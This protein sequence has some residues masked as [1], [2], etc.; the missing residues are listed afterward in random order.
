MA[1]TAPETFKV[2]FETTAGEFVV[3][4][5]RELAPV[6]V[7]RFHDL[8]T[9]GYYDGCRFFRVVPNF[10]VQFGMHGDPKTGA[11]WR[12]ADIK[13][14]PVKGSN[15]KKTVCFATAGP[16]TRTTQLFINL[17]DNGR[18]DGMGFAAFGEVVEGFEVVEKINP[19]Y[20]EKPRQD[21]IDK[22]G[23]EYLAE[24]FPRLDYIKRAAVIA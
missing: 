23:N 19:E 4:A 13:D 8:V 16:D 20:G 5:K 2:R 18:L 3:E 22:R 7:D 12:K 21:L 14:D 6:G 11:K 1:G 9:Q 24:S 15:R 17:R 10:V